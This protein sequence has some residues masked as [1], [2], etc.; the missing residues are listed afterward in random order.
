MQ[1][2]FIFD[3]HSSLISVRTAVNY[4]AAAPEEV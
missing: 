2:A 4:G 3:F 1:P